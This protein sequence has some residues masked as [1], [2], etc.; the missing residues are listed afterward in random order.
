MDTSARML[1]L[2][3]LL[4]L[5]RH[6]SGAELAERLEVSERTLRRDVDRLRQLGYLVES[7]RG[8]EGGY[9]MAAGASLPPMVFEHDEAVA[10]AI[11]LRDVAHGDDTET[12][13]ASVRA[14]AKLVAI[15]PPVVRHQVEIVADVT[16]SR[17]TG[18][19]SVTPPPDVLGTVAQA[20]RDGVRLTFTYRTADQVETQRYVEPYRL[21]TRGRR[22]YL[23]A[24]DPDRD[25]WRT[26][27]VDRMSQPSPSRNQFTP[28]ALPADDLA[29]YVAE[30][31]RALR[32]TH[33][34]EIIV[35][36][37]GDTA[38]KA[39]GRWVTVEDLAADRCRL[40]MTTDSF[41]WPLLAVSSLNAEFEVVG[42]A[43]LKDHLA[44]VGVLLAR[45]T[46]PG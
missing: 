24:F 23:V 1:R 43:A 12:A 7:V 44:G 46:P 14:L 6:W 39:I 10:L 29:E 19:A 9:Q 11:G 38:R 15:L 32:T 26:F 42:P 18:W 21:V 31:I 22:W 41:D 27:R 3:S 36:V 20:C 5:H 34:V 4:Q 8:I 28:R 40:T 30:R 37:D 2:L 35:E 33:H 13:A 16:D 25:D 17:A 45:N